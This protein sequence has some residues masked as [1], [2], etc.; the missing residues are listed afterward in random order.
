MR[1]YQTGNQ[2]WFK[3]TP[4]YF[5]SMMNALDKSND[6]GSVKYCRTMPTDSVLSNPSPTIP[7]IPVSPSTL[8]Y[9]AVRSV[10]SVA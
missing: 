9:K 4:E 7:S 5:A 1:M 10:S 2:H 6:W 3:C 8:F